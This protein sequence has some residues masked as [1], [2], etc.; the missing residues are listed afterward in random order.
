MPDDKPKKRPTLPVIKITND[1]R[2]VVGPPPGV[3]VTPPAPAPTIPEWIVE[4]QLVFA[5]QAGDRKGTSEAWLVMLSDE[6]QLARDAMDTTHRL[7]AWSR[8]EVR[9]VLRALARNGTIQ[10]KRDEHGRWLYATASVQ[11]VAFLHMFDVAA[12]AA[13]DALAAE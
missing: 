10:H 9:H 1:E 13:A 6:G 12:K 4:P 8:V 2:D 5:V 11:G 7:G 3:P